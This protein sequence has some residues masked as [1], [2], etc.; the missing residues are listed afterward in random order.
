[1]FHNDGSIYVKEEGS[2]RKIF[3]VIK[4]IPTVETVG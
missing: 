1:M 2:Q 3:M 4:R